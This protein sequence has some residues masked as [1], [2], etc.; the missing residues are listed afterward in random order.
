MITLFIEKVKYK[1]NWV[2]V[3][4]GSL[5]QL[6]NVTERHHPF[7]RLI[8]LYNE[9]VCIT[10][11]KLVQDGVL[12]PVCILYDVTELIATFFL[13]ELGICSIFPADF[14]KI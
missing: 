10:H 9:Q 1:L 8:F 11:L 5:N 3:T 2:F 6:V 14:E 13:F 7:L 12:E 4:K